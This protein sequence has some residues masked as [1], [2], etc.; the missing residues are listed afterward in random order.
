MSG[1]FGP[2]IAEIAHE[3]RERVA[4][5]YALAMFGDHR[6]SAD[7]ADSIIADLC[8]YRSDQLAHVVE[9]L[10]G[11]D[12]RVLAEIAVQLASPAAQ[13]DAQQIFEQATRAIHGSEDNPTPTAADP[14][15]KS[16]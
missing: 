12:P 4:A 9:H 11:A 2:T 1:S 5:F 13:S 14:F 6:G 15:R 3:V 10:A 8:R 7:V 16:P